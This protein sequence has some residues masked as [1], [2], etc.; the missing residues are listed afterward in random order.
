MTDPRPT[1]PISALELR[2]YLVTFL[3]VVY[4]ISWSAIDPPAAT[5]AELSARDPEPQRFVWIDALPPPQRPAVALPAG[6]QLASEPAVTPAPRVVRA[7]ERVPRVRTR[8]S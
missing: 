1:S 8:S 7:P 6:W 5:S 2:L 3:A 4:T